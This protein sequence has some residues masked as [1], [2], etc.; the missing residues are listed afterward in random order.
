MTRTTTIE[1][2]S[3]EYYENT[4]HYVMCSKFLHIPLFLLYMEGKAQSSIANHSSFIGDEHW[5]QPHLDLCETLGHLNESLFCY[6]HVFNYQRLNV[7][8]LSED[9]ILIVYRNLASAKQVADFIADARQLQ[10]YQQAAMDIQDTISIDYEYTGRKANGTWS[11]HEGSAG[12][13]KL[14]K[15]VKAMIPFVRFHGEPWQ[16]ATSQIL[17]YRRGGHYAPHHDYIEY[18]SPKQWDYWKVMY[19]ERFATF[20]VMLQPATKGGGTVFPLIHTTVMPSA[21]DA[22]FWTNTN[23]YE[24]QDP[25][26]LHGACPVWEGEKVAA[27]LWVRGRD[28]KLLQMTSKNGNMDIE[29]LTNPNLVNK[30]DY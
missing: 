27:V 2:S 3:D 6:T 23:V 5:L 12:I 11:D 18:Q 13:A 19:G 8:V 9:P 22:I 30:G 17:F 24:E 29:K 16:I 25:R 20:L 26:S 21:G 15:R 4:R 10:L 1:S 14:F 28:Q 7:E